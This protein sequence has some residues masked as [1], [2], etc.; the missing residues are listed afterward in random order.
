M[1]VTGADTTQFAEEPFETVLEIGCEGANG[2][3]P[4]NTNEIEPAATQADRGVLDGVWSEFEDRTVKRLD[5]ITMKYDHSEPVNASAAAMLKDATGRGQCTAWTQLFVLALR[6]QG[7]TVS[8]TKLFAA[9][10]YNQF[11]VRLMKAQGSGQTDYQTRRFGF[12]EVIASSLWPDRIYDPSYGAMTEKSGNDARTV[13][14][15]YEDEN[16]ERHLVVNLVNFAII[17]ADPDTKGQQDLQW[18]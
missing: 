17:S 4:R 9:P 3:R 16:V 5:G 14:L 15:I 7:V 12:H 18:N 2:L 11:E 8:S 6:A 10:N 13:R 1:Y